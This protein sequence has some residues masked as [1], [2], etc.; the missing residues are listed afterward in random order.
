MSLYDGESLG[1]DKETLAE[2]W[3]YWDDLRKSGAAASAEVMAAGADALESTPILAG[4]AATT[5][6]WSNQYTAFSALTDKQLEIVAVPNG[7]EGSG[8]YLKPSQLLSAYSRTDY[9]EES[10]MLI[11]FLLNN[12]DANMILGTE[13]GISGNSEIR[14]MLKDEVPASERK[15]FEYLDYV[16]GIAPPLPPPPPQGAGEIDPLLGRSYEDVAFGR[17]DIDAAV[18]KYFREAERILN[19]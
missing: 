11:D 14:A 6:Q 3:T 1:F 18:D 9:P 16:S 2:W 15:T 12:K 19:A 8:Q 7:P 10:A 5:F 13:R 17:S 4:K